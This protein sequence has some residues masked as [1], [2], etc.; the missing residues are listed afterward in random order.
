MSQ[1]NIIKLLER[2]KKPISIKQMAEKLDISTS[3]VGSSIRKLM[4]QG[5][6]ITTFKGRVPFYEINKELIAKHP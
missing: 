4:K 2:S 1:Q 6:I 5:L 3:T